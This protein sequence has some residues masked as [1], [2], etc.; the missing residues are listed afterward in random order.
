MEFTFPVNK[1]SNMEEDTNCS[2]EPV[3]DAGAESGT[4]SPAEVELSDAAARTATPRMTITT[5][6]TYSTTTSTP[7]TTLDPQ[8]ELQNG[9]TNPEAPPSHGPSHVFSPEW[10]SLSKEEVV[11]KVKGTIYG[12]AIGDAIGLAT[13][14]MSKA[15]AR[16]LYGEQGPGG[17]QRTYVDFH[18]SRWDEGDWTEDTDQM[19][20]ILQSVVDTGGKVERHHFAKRLND[21]MIFGFPELG[22]VGGMGIGTMVH[23]ALANVQFLSS[24]HEAAREVWERSGRYLATNE[25]LM[26]T[27]VLGVVN[28]N[29][30]DKVTS[31]TNEICA[32]T[33]AD[34]RCAASCVAMTTTLA[35]MLQGKYDPMKEEGNKALVAE[36][37]EY[38][39]KHLSLDEQRREL[40]DHVMSSSLEDLKLDEESSISYTF[41]ALGAGFY[42][43][44]KATDFRKTIMELIM[45]GGDADSNGAVCGALM[46]CKLGFKALP[47][48]LLQFKNRQ[49]LDERVDSFLRLIG[50]I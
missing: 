20:V 2:V 40:R 15:E 31:N 37:L 27:S 25:A 6:T 48:D 29:N 9:A 7:S 1:V 41:K 50:L 44:R 46:G 11:D 12:Q 33:H 13:E 23:K 24:P 49:W 38:A 19:L 32:V 14:C 3:G 28:F 36:A 34:P 21:W 42:G 26:R 10:S 39:C 45:E 30:L 43:L 17:Y 22:D 35:L 18:R 16:G 5:S 8:G 4:P 47:Q